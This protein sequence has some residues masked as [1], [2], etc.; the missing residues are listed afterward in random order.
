MSNLDLPSLFMLLKKATSGNPILNLNS[1][2]IFFT[3]TNK[4]VEDV[5]LN[6]YKSFTKSGGFKRLKSVLGEGLFTGEEPRHMEKKKE[7]YSA[8]DNDHI[9]EYEDSISLVVDDVL[10]KWFD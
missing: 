1:E 10:S 5:A 9:K 3:F 2:N 6:Q 7:I 8:F 4:A